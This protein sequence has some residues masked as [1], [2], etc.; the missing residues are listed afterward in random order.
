MGT[1]VRSRQVC[2][3]MRRPVS[4]RVTTLRMALLLVLLAAAAVSPGQALCPH[5]E[6]DL[7][8]WSQAST[9]EGLT[10]SAVFILISPRRQHNIYS[11]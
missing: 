4:D 1:S 8:P 7:Q 10:V 6:A 11:H 3:Y 9:W 2:G 5:E